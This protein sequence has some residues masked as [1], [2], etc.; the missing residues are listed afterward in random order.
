MTRT[1]VD[2]WRRRSV[3]GLVSLAITLFTLTSRVKPVS[4]QSASRLDEQDP[5]AQALGY[6]HDAKQVDRKRFG[7]YQAG[8]AC[9]NCQLFQVKSGSAWGPCPI[10]GG[11]QVAATGWCN[12]YVRKA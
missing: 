2:V 4:A 1:N 5:A 7:K 10:Y 9:S 11:R 3:L 6:R 8:Q 12:A